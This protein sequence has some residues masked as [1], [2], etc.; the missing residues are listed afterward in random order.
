MGQFAVVEELDGVDQLVG[1][2]AD[3]VQRVGMV[4]V[5]LLKNGIQQLILCINVS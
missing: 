4:V 2:V 5:L 3:L 1:D